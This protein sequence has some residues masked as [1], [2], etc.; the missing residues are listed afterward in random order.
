M[1]YTKALPAPLLLPAIAW[2][3]G[4]VLAY[5]LVPPFILLA[6]IAAALLLAAVFVRPWRMC[7]ILLLFVA[8]GALRYQSQPGNQSVLRELLSSHKQIQQP[9]VFSVRQVLSVADNRYAVEI[10]SLAGTA[11]HEQA[12]YMSQKPLTPGKRYAGIAELNPMVNDPLL[13]IY[14]TRYAAIAYQLGNLTEYRSYRWGSFVA[15]LRYKM[16]RNLDAKLGDTAG[17]A[18]GLLLSDSTAKQEFRTELSQSGIMHLIVVSGLHVWLIYLVI[19]S[20]L[21]IFV[22]RNLAELIFLPLILL[23]A[24][25][26]NWAPPITRAIIM[27]G[28]TIAARWLQ[29]PLGG[30]QSLSLSLLIITLINPQELFSIGFQ[31]SFVAVA[32]ILFGLPRF[33][34]YPGEAMSKHPWQRGLENL[35]HGIIMSVLVS[36]AISPLTL[37]YFGRASL[38]GILGNIIGIPLIGMLLP[39]S[40]LILVLP[41]SLYLSHALR[42]SYD[43][44][45]GI[46]QGWFQFCAALP[47]GIDAEYLNLSMAI[48]LAA[49]LAWLFIVIRGKFRL[50]LILLLPSVLLVGALYYFPQ[51]ESH[52]TIVDVFSCGV[53]DCSLVQFENG[54]NLMID[55]GGGKAFTFADIPPSEADMLSNSWMQL[56]LLPWL[57]RNGINKIDYLVLT[58]LHADHY[59]G[60]L[61][62]M[63][64]LKVK[65]LFVS[66]ATT[67]QALWQ[68][69]SS[70]PYF[71]PLQVHVIADTCSFNLGDANL[72]FLHPDKGFVTKDENERSLVCR[73]DFSDKRILFTGDIGKRSED[74]LAEKY[75]GELACDYLKVPHHGSRNSSSEAFLA[76]AEPVEA[77]LTTS[78]RNRFGFPH[79]EAVL[80]YNRIHTR[81]RSTTEGSIRKK[82]D[83]S[84]VSKKP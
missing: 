6:G 10:D 71:K 24:A 59:G 39:L 61:T 25:L 43:A 73:L 45:I 84:K 21:R 57:G 56:H 26:N 67:Q 32:V 8:L 75:P 31:L 9:L 28:T 60:L 80:R 44:L 46:W 16:L 65:H 15:A 50:A 78:A 76:D 81:L 27:I 23:F 37:Y 79:Q 19:V 7:F 14:P 64:N 55:T 58:H 42:L 12:I 52:E 83:S 3:A 48:A 41:Q 2:A 33:S 5:F 66:K 11:L 40:G 35:V 69:V 1:A 54:T 49:A 17:W 36:L 4:I 72:K 74:Y 63:Q 13:D 68:Y 18:K 20:L 47:F 51:H 22:H 82:I 77:W 62:V 29:R 30:A 34:L 70:L 38:N 53:A